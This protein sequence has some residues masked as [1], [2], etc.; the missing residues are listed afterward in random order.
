MKVFRLEM[1]RQ[2]KKM[3]V[4]IYRYNGSKSMMAI[5]VATTVSRSSVPTT[6]SRVSDDTK[7]KAKR[8]ISC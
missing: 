8:I 6:I 4:E 2:R 3:A 1:K 7:V 5:V